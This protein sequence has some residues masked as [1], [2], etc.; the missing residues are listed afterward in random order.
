MP[1]LLQMCHEG[2]VL[3]DL[4]GLAPAI[5]HDVAA[6]LAAGPTALTPAELDRLRYFTTDLLDDWISPRDADE[7]LFIAPALMRSSADL[8]LAV[9]NRW[10]GNGKW[11][12]RALRA[13]DPERAAAAVAALEAFG[14]QGDPEPLAAFAREALARAGGPLFEGYLAR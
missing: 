6:R 4:D 5:K 7:A 11:T 3:Q 9:A 2:I 1:S 8:L 12:L 13:A 10:T 14:A